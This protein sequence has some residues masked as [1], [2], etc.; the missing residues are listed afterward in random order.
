MPFFSSKRQEAFHEP[1]ETSPLRLSR[2]KVEDFSELNR[3][4]RV[5]PDQGEGISYATWAARTW[6]Q[7]DKVTRAL[8]LAIGATIIIAAVVLLTSVAFSKPDP[9]QAGSSPN[10]EKT[11]LKQSSN[12]NEAVLEI[13]QGKLKWNILTSREGRNYYAFYK[14]PYAKPPIGELRFEVRKLYRVINCFY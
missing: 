8:I 2:M 3:P 9:E 11:L 6:T 7:W 4:Q 12:V 10:V 5:D 13:P 1:S 14:V